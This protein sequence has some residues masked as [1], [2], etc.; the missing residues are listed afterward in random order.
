[1]KIE[2]HDVFTLDL[3]LPA[4]ANLNIKLPVTVMRSLI[5]LLEGKRSAILSITHIFFSQIEP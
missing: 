2:E 3:M 4:G 5:L 1:M